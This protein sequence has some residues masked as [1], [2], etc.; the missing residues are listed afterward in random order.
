VLRET[1]R[2]RSA[3]SAI[4]KPAVSRDGARPGLRDDST[5]VR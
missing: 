2:Q 4:G 3:H 5:T 1:Q